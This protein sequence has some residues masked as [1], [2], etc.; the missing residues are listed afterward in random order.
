MSGRIQSIRLLSRLV[1]PP[2]KNAR[3]TNRNARFVA[4]GGMNAFEADF[5][6]QFG[7]DRPGRTESLNGVAPDPAVEF[8]DLGV[9]QTGIGL[10]EAH[11]PGLLFISPEAKGVV[12]E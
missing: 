11:Q 12:G 3:E 8:E 10:R 9:I 2:A 4:L 1:A 5:K 6:H 7:F